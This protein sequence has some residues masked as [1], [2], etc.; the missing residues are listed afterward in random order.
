MRGG[1]WS[2]CGEGALDSLGKA[3]AAAHEY[4]M[5]WLGGQQ[6]MTNTLAA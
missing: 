1:E 6:W 4:R 2:V 5:G 3:Q